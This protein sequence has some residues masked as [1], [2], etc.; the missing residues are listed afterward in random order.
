MSDSDLSESDLLQIEE[1]AK[2]FNTKKATKWGLKKFTSWCERRRIEIDWKHISA[3]DLSAILRKFYA[4]IKTDKKNDLA[5]ISLVGIRAAIHRHITG[6]PISRSL[7]I[8]QDS[9]FIPAN[10]MFKSRC[11]SY[12]KEGK[13]KA[14]HYPAIEPEDMKKIGKY[15]ENYKTDPIVLLHAVWFH[16]CYHFGRRAREGWT[17]MMKDTFQI[18]CD[19][20]GQRYVEMNKTEVTKNH[21]N[22]CGSKCNEYSDQRMYGDGVQIFEL[23]ISKLNPNLDRLFQ[24]PKT[25]HSLVDDFWYDN[26]PIGKNVLSNMLQNISRQANLSKIYTCHS[27]RASTIT[28]LYQSGIKPQ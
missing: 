5:P 11:K 12:Q 20:G 3:D 10:M 28:H 4:E 22:P 1:N 27:V 26:I 18:N 17:K 9:A 25:R 24:R 7:N 8:L 2:P 23:Y 6:A 19:A 21:Q 16:L 13:V 15:F 14:T